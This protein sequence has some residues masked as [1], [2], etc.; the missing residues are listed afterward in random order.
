MSA[1]FPDRESRVADSAPRG[2]RNVGQIVDGGKRSQRHS[3]KH[4]DALPAGCRFRAFFALSDSP[5]ELWEA[6]RVL[7]C[8][9]KRRT[10]SETSRRDRQGRCGV[11]NPK[12]V[13]D[14]LW[15]FS[16]CWNSRTVKKR[17]PQGRPG[18]FPG[19]CA[20]NSPFC[21][22]GGLNSLGG[23]CAFYRRR[24]G[25]SGRGISRGDRPIIACIG[26]AMVFCS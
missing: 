16:N 6:V 12:S 22:R 8:A 10:P 4:A 26:D 23:I 25:A 13:S 11:I 1:A 21:P 19:S 24:M 20:I 15:E 3:L 7:R 17:P 9:R 5:V 2:W 14:R 18:E